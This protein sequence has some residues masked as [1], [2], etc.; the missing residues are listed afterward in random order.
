MVSRSRPRSVLLRSTARC[1]RVLGTSWSNPTGVRLR[2]GEYRYT[3]DPPQPGERRE[4]VLARAH[5]LMCLVI[6]QY[7]NIPL[8]VVAY[9]IAG[10]PRCV[11][12]RRRVVV[13]RHVVAHPCVGSPGHTVVLRVPVTRELPL[14]VCCGDMDFASS[15]C[16]HWGSESHQFWM[17]A[18]LDG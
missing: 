17:P 18:V 9:P 7:A 4:R 8:G 11:V 1:R 14:A 12:A 10:A 2:S 13:R 15:L 5:A 6:L 16:K 3:D